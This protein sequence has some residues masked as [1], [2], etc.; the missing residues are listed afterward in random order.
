MIHFYPRIL[1]RHPLVFVSG[2]SWWHYIDDKRIC[3]YLFFPILSL[4]RKGQRLSMG[5]IQ[6]GWLMIRFLFKIQRGCRVSDPCELQSPPTAKF[7]NHY[8]LDV[9]ITVLGT[10]FW[11]PGIRKICQFVLQFPPLQ[12][13]TSQ[14]FL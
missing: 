2:V 4:V 13:S 9:E 5:L 6:K 10:S 7:K 12:N 8:L 11:F 14:L 3:I 1:L